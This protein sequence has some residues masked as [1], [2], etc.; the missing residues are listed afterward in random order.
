MPGEKEKTWSS[1]VW[2]SQVRHG[3]KPATKGQ[4]KATTKQL[5][6]MPEETVTGQVTPQKNLLVW[7]L[8][9]TAILSYNT[10]RAGKRG[11]QKNRNV[12]SLDYQGKVIL[13]A[14]AQCKQIVWVTNFYKS[15]YCQWVNKSHHG[16][17]AIWYISVT[18][19]HFM[20]GCVRT[21]HF[22]VLYVQ[23]NA[24]IVS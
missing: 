6:W 12:Q 3:W 21:V 24:E 9:A 2:S 18:E 22:N 5:Y 13:M 16:C 23:V 14:S 8:S 20:V 17:V 19:L 11:P 10:W 1:H 7:I 15:N 4:A